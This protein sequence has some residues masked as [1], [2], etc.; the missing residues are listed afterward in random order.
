MGDQIVLAD[1]VSHVDGVRRIHLMA[2][3]EIQHDAPAEA[4]IL[5]YVEAGSHHLQA[6][7][8]VRGAIDI[9]CEGWPRAKRFVISP[10]AKG[11]R[12][13]DVVKAAAEEYLR[14]F[15]GLPIYAFTGRLPN[16]VENGVEIMLG[17]H[18][19]LLF[20]ADWMME[21]FVVVGG[22]DPTM[23]QTISQFAE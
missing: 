19:I 15:G 16:G 7:W 13:S 8:L 20:A 21:R 22:K 23:P 5:K 9:K 10:I 1:S 2:N 12:M 4:V 11:E 6:E 14:L 3:T 17:R 18:E